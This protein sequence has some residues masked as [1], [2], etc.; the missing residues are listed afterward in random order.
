MEDGICRPVGESDPSLASF[1]PVVLQRYFDEYPNAFL[2]QH[3]ISS[4]ESFLFNELPDIIQSENPITILKEPLDAKAG[5]YKYKTEIY[6]G[7]DVANTNDLAI[8]IGSPI[9]TLDD[10]ITIRRMFPNE[11]RLRDITYATTFQADILI[12]MTFTN[13]SASGEYTKQVRELN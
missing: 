1:A 5:V 2:T 10:G 11:A 12:R 3:H 8:H 4:Y 13:A 7:G 6:V 9:I